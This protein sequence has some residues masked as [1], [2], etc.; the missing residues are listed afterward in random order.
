M[1]ERTAVQQFAPGSAL[2]WRRRVRW[3][4]ISASDL[5]AAGAAVPAFELAI[6]QGLPLEGLKRREKSH[7]SQ[8]RYM[9]VG[10][11]T[12]SYMVHGLFRTLCQVG[13]QGRW[14]LPEGS[15]VEN[16]TRSYI[17]SMHDD[18][19]AHL[20][21]FERRHAWLTMDKPTLATLRSTPNQMRTRHLR[22]PKK[23]ACLL[24]PP[25]GSLLCHPALRRPPKT[26]TGT[27]SSTVA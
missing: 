25:L 5:G 23:A 7:L 26:C 6:S 9:Q 17:N 15:S 22:S 16:C 8:I 10:Q 18:M 2:A 20:A 27:A 24:Q 13:T 4:P 19:C 3:L 1:A 14:A 11:R 21:R 12:R